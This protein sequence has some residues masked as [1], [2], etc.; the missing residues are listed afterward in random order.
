MTRRWP[1]RGHPRVP[2]LYCLGVTRLGRQLADE[3]PDRRRQRR[4]AGH[5]IAAGDFPTDQYYQTTGAVAGTGAV[6]TVKVAANKVL[7]PHWPVEV[8]ECD[9]AP[10]SSNDCDL[11]TILT[12]D[13]LTKRRVEAAANGS[14]TIHFL[15][16]SP[17]PDKWDPASVITVGHSHP[18][19]LWIGD[20]PS[21]WATT[22][23]VSSPV[24][25]GGQVKKAGTG[26]PR[27]VVASDP[28]RPESA[29][30]SDL[31][32]IFVVGV[33]ALLVVAAGA[34]FM[35]ARRRRDAPA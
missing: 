26:S 4:A 18:T 17:L 16:W 7:R 10:A 21:E 35:G 11:L 32:A 19:A 14:V 15:L 30:G 1:S 27:R 23:L 33:A 29:G 8:L 22:G 31:T 13:Q 34:V 9:A 28:L 2:R 12:Y 25:V 20:D 3:R 5:R 24:V 6:V